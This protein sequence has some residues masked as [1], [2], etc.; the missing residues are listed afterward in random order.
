MSD[1]CDP[2]A[3]KSIVDSQSILKNILDNMKKFKTRSKFITNKIIRIEEREKNLNDMFSM[4]LD[5]LKQFV[6]ENFICSSSDIERLLTIKESTW[7]ITKEKKLRQLTKN[8]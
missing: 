8:I 7:N 3:A 4:Q 6:S 1:K 2:K 5:E